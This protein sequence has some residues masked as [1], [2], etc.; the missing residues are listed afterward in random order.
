MKLRP[1]HLV[2]VGLFIGLFLLVRIVVGQ[3]IEKG[4]ESPVVDVPP[5][6]PDRAAAI[7]RAPLLVLDDDAALLTALGR[8]DGATARRVHPDARPELMQGYADGLDRASEHVRPALTRAYRRLG[9]WWS[10]PTEAADHPIDD[11][12]ELVDPEQPGGQPVQHHRA[13]DPADEP[14]QIMD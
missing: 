11:A 6:G 9:R 2:F 10:L 14:G 4:T 7:V 8:V 13:D 3:A 1:M 5:P 12:G